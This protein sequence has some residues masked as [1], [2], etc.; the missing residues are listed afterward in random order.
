MTITACNLFFNCKR[1]RLIFKRTFIG[2]TRL[3]QRCVHLKA[4][5]HD[6][7]YFNINLLNDARKPATPGKLL[8]FQKEFLGKH[9]VIGGDRMCLLFLF[10]HTPRHHVISDYVSFNGVP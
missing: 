7:F 6:I 4:G 10:L 2:K 5:M 3:S 9:I 1:G 8:S